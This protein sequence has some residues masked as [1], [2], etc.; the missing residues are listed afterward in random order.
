MDATQYANVQPVVE[1]TCSEKGET[2]FFQPPPIR[3]LPQS[4]T[5]GFLHG[6][7]KRLDLWISLVHRVGPLS[8]LSSSRMRDCTQVSK[9][10]RFTLYI[11]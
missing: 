11:I 2:S 4:Q 7:L 5:H 10:L 6:H 9:A 1:E 8:S 3:H